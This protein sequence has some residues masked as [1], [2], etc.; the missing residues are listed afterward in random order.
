MMSTTMKYYKHHKTKTNKSIVLIIIFCLLS[1]IIL[2]SFINFCKYPEQYILTWKYQLYNDI[3]RGDTQAIA[4]YNNTYVANG[5][6][7]FDN[8]TTITAMQK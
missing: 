3:V 1:T 6:I 4:Y 8:N 7:L 2:S 5:K